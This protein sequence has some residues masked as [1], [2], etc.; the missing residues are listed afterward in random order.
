MEP[1]HTTEKLTAAAANLAHGAT[2]VPADAPAA[3]AIDARAENFANRIRA[4]NAGAA[5]ANVKLENNKLIFAVSVPRFFTVT[6]DG[7]AVEVIT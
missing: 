2:P 6:E 5:V 1:I 3:M 7:T 4:M